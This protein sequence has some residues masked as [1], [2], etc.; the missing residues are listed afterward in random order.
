MLH[1][2]ATVIVDEAVEHGCGG[3]ILEELDRIG[4][5]ERLP[6]ADWHAMW[7]CHKLKQCVEYETEER[8][9]FM[10]TVTPKNSSKRCNECG[11]VRD[12]NRRQDEFE[13][14][15]WGN[16]SHVDYNAARNVAE[17]SLLQDH[18]PSRGR[19]ISQ[20]ALK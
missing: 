6:H 18:Q 14:Q 9:V 11:G 4:I 7:A 1:T 2:V 20:Y 15:R 3:I 5:R 17:L 13:R 19:S 12:D 16:Q 8:G 10:D